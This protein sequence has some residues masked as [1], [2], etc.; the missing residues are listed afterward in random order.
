MALFTDYDLCL[1]DWPICFSRRRTRTV[2]W[3][4][5]YTLQALTFYVI[6]CLY[7]I[8]SHIPV[9]INTMCKYPYSKTLV[10]SF[11]F[12][13]CNHLIPRHI[14]FIAHSIF[15]VNCYTLLVIGEIFL[16]PTCT[17]TY[18]IRYLPVR[19]T[20]LIKIHLSLQILFLS[21]GFDNTPTLCVEFILHL[22]LLEKYLI[23]AVKYLLTY[24]HTLIRPLN[25]FL[26]Y[27]LILN[28][29]LRSLFYRQYKS[30][31][32]NKILLNLNL[33]FSHSVTYWFRPIN[34]FTFELFRLYS[35]LLARLLFIFVTLF[36]RS[37]VKYMFPTCS[38]VLYLSSQDCLA[39]WDTRVSTFR[40]FRPQMVSSWFI[41][42]LIT[43]TSWI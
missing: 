40:K 9:Y 39:L 14:Y 38:I 12:P 28:F 37:L 43:S 8:F 5:S 2:S 10:F 41:R 24:V 33:V 42:P 20:W 3:T 36:I 23:S 1:M 35:Y 17:Y 18:L 22:S 30:L 21:T 6:A 13:T 15:H 27:W 7:N 25:W 34:V 32:C 19:Y 26:S 29:S 11:K 4:M 31:H 16:I